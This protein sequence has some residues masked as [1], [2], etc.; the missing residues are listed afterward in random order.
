MYPTVT[1]G[2]GVTQ[3]VPANTVI[4]GAAGTSLLTGHFKGIITDINTAA[5]T[6]DG[7]SRR[8]K[9]RCWI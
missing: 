4:S 1:V 5:K 6:V 3:S 9:I 8:N 2:M 7:K